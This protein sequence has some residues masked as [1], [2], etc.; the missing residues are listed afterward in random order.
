PVHPDAVVG[1]RLQAVSPVPV[2]EQRI[3]LLLAGAGTADA[4][5]VQHPLLQPGDEE[6]LH[7]V[8]R[9]AQAREQP[10]LSALSAAAVDHGVHEPD[11]ARL[12]P[13]LSPGRYVR[14]PP[15]AN[16][17]SGPADSG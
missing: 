9:D 3:P 4:P 14:R 15:G 16:A 17:G 7:A 5:V 1:S 8:A 6:I 10:R 12:R 13:G 2:P 11:R